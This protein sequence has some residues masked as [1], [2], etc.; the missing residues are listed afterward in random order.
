MAVWAVRRGSLS[1][2]P[3][4]EYNDQA[5]AFANH[6]EIAS[7]EKHG[8]EAKEWKVTMA[9]SMLEKTPIV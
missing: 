1:V 5:F 6:E 4:V 8:T 3:F 9:G 7:A 2:N